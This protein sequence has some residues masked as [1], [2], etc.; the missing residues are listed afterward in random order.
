MQGCGILSDPTQMYRFP[1]DK[2]S[3]FILTSYPIKTPFNTFATIVDPDQ[4]DLVRAA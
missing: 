1:E 2:L 3:L 4:A